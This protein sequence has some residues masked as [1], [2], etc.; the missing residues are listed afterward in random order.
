M[1]GFQPAK[2]VTDILSEAL[3]ERKFWF[4]RQRLE[5]FLTSPRSPAIAPQINDAGITVYTSHCSASIDLL[6]EKALEE[7]RNGATVV[8]YAEK[9]ARA[10]IVYSLLL[11][12]F[13]ELDISFE[14]DSVEDAFFDAIPQLKSELSGLDLRIGET[15]LDGDASHSLS[16]LQDELQNIIKDPRSKNVH[17]FI[18]WIGSFDCVNDEMMMTENADCAYIN[19]QL[20]AFTKENDCKMIIGDFQGPSMPY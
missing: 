3:S 4:L 20:G 11:L 17:C 16:H 12:L 1:I 5:A 13:N 8:F 15:Q 2:C 19:E 10:N 7:A 6:S 14:G 18:T 9:T